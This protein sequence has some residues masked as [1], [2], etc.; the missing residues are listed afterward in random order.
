[1]I[2]QIPHI[3]L[4]PPILRIHERRILL[5]KFLITNHNYDAI[6]SYPTRLYK[7][8]ITKIYLRDKNLS[9][10]ILQKFTQLKNV[11]IFVN[12]KTCEMLSHKYIHLKGDELHLA[13]HLRSLSASPKILSYSAHSLDEIIKANEMGIDY[14]FI[15]PIFAVDGKNPPLGLD[16]FTQIPKML[17]PKIF[18]LGGINADN[19]HKFEHLGICGI[20]GIRVFAEIFN[21]H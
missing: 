21:L 7:H 8:N 6:L 11:E 17:K 18:A 1:M 14:I 5:E 4:I 3:L 12:Y 9:P 20:A 2:L 15:S 16:I 13:L 10:H 19:I